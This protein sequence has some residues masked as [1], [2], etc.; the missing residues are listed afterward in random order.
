M[1]Y[2]FLTGEEDSTPTTTTINYGIT[3]IT[4]NN[5]SMINIIAVI[6]RITI[7]SDLLV[8]FPK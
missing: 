3:L 7:A 1:Y 2:Y 8:I 5:I 4:A 6:L